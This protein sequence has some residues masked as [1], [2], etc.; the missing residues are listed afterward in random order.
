MITVKLLL[1]ILAVI[2]LFLATL[3]VKPVR[4][5]LLA[6]GLCLWAVAT[7]IGP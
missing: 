5:N 4:V 3:D 2:C 7:M 1:M 6:G